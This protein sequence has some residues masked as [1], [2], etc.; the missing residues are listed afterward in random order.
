M[1]NIVK[2]L[3]GFKQEQAEEEKSPY[4]TIL[5]LIQLFRDFLKFKAKDYIK[6]VNKAALRED[7]MLMN[8]MFPFA[9]F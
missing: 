8:A 6:E 5:F 3:H 7:F 4:A 2:N 9:V 1:S